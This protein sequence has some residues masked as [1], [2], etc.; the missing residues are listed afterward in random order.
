[1]ALSEHGRDHLESLWGERLGK[2]TKERASRLERIRR[3]LMD[4]S[5]IYAQR[6]FRG[7]LQPDLDYVRAIGDARVDCQLRAYMFDGQTLSQAVNAEI[8]SDAT[9]HME[10]TSDTLIGWKKNEMRSARPVPGHYSDPIPDP[11]ELSSWFVDIQSE[12]KDELRRK[13]KI[14]MYESTGCEDRSGNAHASASPNSTVVYGD[15]IINN[16]QAGALG[17]GSRGIVNLSE[18]WKEIEQDTDLKVLAVE[19][20][21]LRMEYRNIA[22]SREDDKQVALLGYAAEEAEKGNGP[23]MAAILSNAGRKVLNVAKDIG[24]DVAAKVIV[25]LW[26]Q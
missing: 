16:G 25:Q 19:L 15:Q 12:T 21:Q 23:G 24:T 11:S 22:S 18:R 10:S 13:L 26:S 14:Q 4:P 8:L 9:L 2:L 20:D 7:Y 17:R 3:G 5:Q 6:T 1:M